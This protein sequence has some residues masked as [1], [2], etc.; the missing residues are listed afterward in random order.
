MLKIDSILALSVADACNNLYGSKPE[1]KQISVQSTRSEFE[2]DRTVVVFPFTRLSGKSPELT[3]EQIGMY[4]VKNDDNITNFQIVKGFLN[5][6]VS[7]NYWAKALN[8]AVAEKECFGLQAAKSK[9]QVMVEYSS[10]NT[11]KPLHL[12]HLRNNFLGYSVSEI[13]KAAGHDVI[14]VQIIN[15]RGI[16]ICKSMVAWKLFGNN[17]T[18]TSTGEKGD[19]LV[20]RYYVA[21]DKA[22]KKEVAEIISTGKDEETAKS[23]A[24]ILLAARDLLHKWE[25]GDSEVRTLWSTMNRWVYDGFESTYKEMG[26]DFDKLYYESDTYLIGKS[27]VKKGLADGVFTQRED[28]SIWVDLSDVGLDEKLLLRKDGTA[29]YMTQDI[30]TAIL[31]FEDYPSLDR[32]VYTVGNEQEYHFK[33]LF[34]IL[35]KLGFP[36]A[37]RCHHLSYGMVE[38]P[39]GKMKSREGTVVDADDLLLEMRTS[40]AQLASEAGKLD[41]IPPSER[42]NLYKKVGYGALKYFLLKVD[43]RKSMMFDP[44]GSIDFIGNTGPYIQFNYVRAR[45]VLRNAG[46]EDVSTLVTPSTVHLDNTERNLLMTALSLPTIIEE[47]ARSYDPSLVANLCYDITKSY[48][49]WYQDHPILK[50]EDSDLRIARLA[51]CSLCSQAI[52]TGM[53]LLGVD[54][55]ENM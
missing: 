32:Q 28:S 55:P 30:G 17:E 45:S 14:K 26:V 31:R 10:P 48:S 8:D 29:V 37:S 21:F 20:G 16:H 24:P 40:A 25:A 39:E 27:L 43:P 22:Y 36:Q 12:G 49:R 3:G 54:M 35:S 18:P 34:E 13:L 44:A 4:L 41:N 38:L 9:P 46:I 15:D 33:V 51:L 6:S 52:K 23:E 19:K 53:G 1:P 5:L 42:D 47:A 2:G 7:D 50:E 11:N